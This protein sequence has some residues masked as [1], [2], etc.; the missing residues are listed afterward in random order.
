MY[1][2]G[3]IAKI[4]N[5]N[6]LYFSCFPPSTNYKSFLILRG[7]G[8]QLFKFEFCAFFCNKGSW[9]LPHHWPK[10]LFLPEDMT[11]QIL[12]CASNFTVRVSIMSPKL[13]GTLRGQGGSEVDFHFLIASD[14]EEC[15]LPVTFSE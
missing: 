2:R 15:Q 1:P 8:Y 10:I 5:L 11:C 6:K 9:F 7:R 12:A 14:R 13:L 3:Q 4:H